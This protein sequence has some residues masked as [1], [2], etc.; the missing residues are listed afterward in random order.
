MHGRDDEEAA[1]AAG[2]QRAPRVFG[3]QE[4]AREEK[5]DERVPA[6]LGELA[7][8]RYVLEAGVRHHG[9]EAPEALERSVDGLAVSRA[10]R[11]VG[12][13]RLPGAG[14]V[15]LE[16][17]REDEGA[18]VLEP[19]SDRAADPAR[20]P[21]DHDR[22]RADLVLLHRV[23]AIFPHHD[24][25]L[26]PWRNADLGLIPSAKRNTFVPVTTFEGL[27][28]AERRLSRRGLLAA[29]AA[30]GSALALGALRPSRL[31][32]AP[33]WPGASAYPAEVPLLWFELA[34]ELVQTTP[35][36]SPPV[37]SRA[38]GY[39]GV[40]LYEALQ[41][42]M[43]RRRSLAGQLNELAPAPGSADGAYHWPTVANG[44]LAS[45]LRSLFPTAT[46]ES[47]RAIDEL[48]RRFSARA[49]A[50]L[51]LG[52]SR[53][54]VARG[55]AVA[56]HVFTWSTTDGGHEA[57][58]NNFPPYDPPGG[59]G[60]WVPTPPDFRPALQ[61]HWGAN[62][63][64]A[65]P[66]GAACTP[67]PPAYSDQVGS[68]FYAEAYECYTAA[69]R[70]TPE[71]EA[72]ARFWSD[73]PGQTPTPPGHSISI[74]TQVARARAVTLAQAAEAYAKV[75]IAVADAFIACWN[76]KYRYTLLRPVTYIQSIVDAGWTPLLTTP[77]FPEYTSGHSVQ[78]AAAAEVLTD[79]FGD[80][81]FV[82]R[83]HESCLPAR[84]FRSFHEAAE[85]AAVSRL[86][87]G[88]HFRAAIERGLEQ[89]CYVGRY[90]SEL[91]TA[92]G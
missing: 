71:Q 68:S 60:L 88:I 16:V 15:G 76:A 3:E 33:T 80:V 75:G 24:R 40:A 25:S 11:Q 73:D 43:P 47:A 10:G 38:L 14:L 62:R 83:T 12:R 6:V 92:D 46:A 23:G 87:G 5:G 42:G 52:V 34:L 28:G 9:V 30:G 65:L 44:A 91:V 45:I 56:A 18:V 27:P 4:R 2:G 49:E 36:F 53:R 74:L 78:S 86:Y 61:P 70:L 1:V 81:A 66:S 77:P 79:L 7:D 39:A 29:A 55:E 72:I 41:P 32:A 48:E 31:L 59:P 35:G 57:F 54:S 64:F 8:G 89:G 26:P 37:A 13:K 50:D 17:D 63:P 51:P 85:E 69:T 82:D 22:S 20:R 67:P 58:R 84:S 21:C 19:L 90:A